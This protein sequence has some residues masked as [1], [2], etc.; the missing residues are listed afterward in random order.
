[1]IWAVQMS[2]VEFHPWNSRRGTREARR[3]AN[4]PRPGRRAW[5]PVQRVAHVVHEVLDELAR[6][7]S[8][9]PAAARGCTS[10]CG[11]RPTTASRTSPGRARVRPR[12]GA[13]RARRRHHDLVAQGPR[14]A[15][16]VRGLQP[17]RARPHDRRGVLR[18]RLPRRP[19]LDPDPVG[20]GRR[21]RPPRLHDLHR[22]RAVRRARRPARA[23][24]TT[25]SSTSRRCWSGPSATSGPSAEPPDDPEMSDGRGHPLGS[26]PWASRSR[27]AS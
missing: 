10:T 2:T 14:P 15:P 23:T 4:R 18:A 8:P 3:V 6:S 26:T 16:A 21:R 27:R 11:S 25:T 5:E 20:G 7:A 12:G 9:R 19:G 1:M 17:G 13:P 24:S 22:A